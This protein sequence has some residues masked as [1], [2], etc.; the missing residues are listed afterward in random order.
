METLKPTVLIVEDDPDLLE[1]LMDFLDARGFSVRG[2]K[3]AQEM[4]RA[5]AE[6]QP[7]LIVMDILLP[8][9]NGIAL[10]RELRQEGNMG[11]LMLT[12][13]NDTQHMLDSLQSGADAYLLK[14]SELSVVEA[15]LRSIMRRL[16]KWSTST[17]LPE[18]DPTTL[19]PTDGTAWHYD[20][21]TWTLTAPTHLSV[22]LN[23]REHRFLLTLCQTPGKTVERPI[24]LDALGKKDT[25][26]NRRSMDVFVR[27]L[28]N[29]IEPTVNLSFPLDTVY[30]VGYAFT[31]PIVVE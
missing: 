24:C 1:D 9:D 8:D 2:A 4:H 19:S 13:M 31:A 5:L 14:D 27:R 18:D 7:D 12:C 15:N 17:P 23:G 3:S 11:I 16:P 26:T 30:G 25:V 22:K 6:N 29:K 20:T 21:I 28:K 10:T